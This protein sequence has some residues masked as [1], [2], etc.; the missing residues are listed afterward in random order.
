MRQSYEVFELM[1]GIWLEATTLRDPY[2]LGRLTRLELARALD[3]GVW[4][5]TYH[6]NLSFRNPGWPSNER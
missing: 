3:L 2:S 1:D 5:D 4:P 6:L